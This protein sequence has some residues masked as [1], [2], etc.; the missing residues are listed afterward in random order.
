MFHVCEKLFYLLERPHRKNGATENKNKNKDESRNE[1]NEQKTKKIVATTI[2]IIEE[3]I[4]PE[5]TRTRCTF[6]EIVCI[7]CGLVF[8]RDLKF[9]KTI[10]QNIR[11]EVDEEAVK[12]DRKSTSAAAAL[13]RQERAKRR[14]KNTKR[15]RRT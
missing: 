9:L 1:Q 11:K 5:L 10:K 4:Q 2:I 3:S 15:K 7:L 14:R 13:T 6:V 8:F 12:K